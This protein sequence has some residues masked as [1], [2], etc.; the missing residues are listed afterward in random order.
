MLAKTVTAVAKEGFKLEKD[1]AD[2][3][4]IAADGSFRDALGVTEKVI[5]ASGDEIGS[6]DEVAAIIGAPKSE[7][8][9]HLITALHEKRRGRRLRRR[10]RCHRNPRRYETLYAVASR[11][12]PRGDALTE[13]PCT[14]RRHSEIIW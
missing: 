13:R 6:A 9:A 11:A 5:L 12:S 8:L 2:L 1:A 3:I 14:K 4:A 10:P 7:I